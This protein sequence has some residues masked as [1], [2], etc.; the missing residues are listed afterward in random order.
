MVSLMQPKCLNA[1]RI[2]NW[3]LPKANNDVIFFF[4]E[5]NNDVIVYIQIVNKKDNKVYYNT[6]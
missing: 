3:I 6:F 4:W 5:N 2:K 1:S